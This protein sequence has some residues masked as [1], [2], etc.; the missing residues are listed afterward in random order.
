VIFFLFLVTIL[1]INVS[2]D[3]DITVGGLSSGGFM[4]TQVHVALSQTIKG[5]AVFAGGPFFVQKLI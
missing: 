2:I 3:N 5:A 1:T 4:A